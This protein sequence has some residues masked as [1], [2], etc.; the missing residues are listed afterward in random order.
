MEENVEA[1][2]VTEQK[3][4]DGFRYGQKNVETGFK[5]VS[6]VSFTC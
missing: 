1:G 6:N 3:C 2:F 5:P 4:T